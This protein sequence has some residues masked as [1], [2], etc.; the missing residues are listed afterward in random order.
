MVNLIGENGEKFGICNFYKAVELSSGLDLALVNEKCN[1]PVVKI[2]N[3]GKVLYEQK[4]NLKKQR[5]NIVKNKEIKFGINIAQND[6][7]IKLHKIEEF[8]NDGDRVRVALYLRGREI[9]FKDS[10]ISFMENLINDIKNFAITNDKIQL[11]GNCIALNF[12]KN[13]G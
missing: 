4:K 2:V 10:A 7:K 9:T 1:P 13:K 12:T 11:V 3:Y 8:I 6:Y 5:A